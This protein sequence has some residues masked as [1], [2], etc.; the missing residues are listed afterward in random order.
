M[1]GAPVVEAPSAV[2][3]STAPPVT[4]PLDPGARIDTPSL[5][6]EE[7][8]RVYVASQWL[9]IWWRFRK[10]KLALLS[11]IVLI[12]F[13]TVVLAADFLSTNPADQTDALLGMAPPQP[14]YWFDGLSF[15]PYVHPIKGNRDPLTGA[16]QLKPGCKSTPFRR[17][18]VARTTARSGCTWPAGSARARGARASSRPRG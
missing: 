10:H 3:R 18:R 16:V 1:E 4:T 13:Y 12:G 6:A 11:G 17:A 7:G 8:E 14:V 15:A 9:L 5:L 2:P